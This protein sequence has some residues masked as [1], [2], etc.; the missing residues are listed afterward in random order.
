MLDRVREHV[1]QALRV[2]SGCRCAYWNKMQGGV[3]RSE[4]ETGEGVDLTCE[5]SS[6]RYKILEAAF[7][8]GVK[9]IGIGKRFIH[10]GVSKTHDQQVVWHYYS[11]ETP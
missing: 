3:P 1:G 5:Y 8:C 6:A 10:L 9:R 4:H 2:N 11:K 7:A